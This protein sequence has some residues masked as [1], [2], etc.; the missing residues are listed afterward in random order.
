MAYLLQSGRQGRDST[1]DE[2]V[3]N[4][5]PTQSRKQD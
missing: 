5:L 4:E 1:W 2:E 3:D